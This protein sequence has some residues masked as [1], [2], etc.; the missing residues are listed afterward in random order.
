MCTQSGIHRTGFPG[1]FHATSAA[2][3][4]SDAN[5]TACHRPSAKWL[6]LHSRLHGPLGFFSPPFSLYNKLWCHPSP[7]ATCT[8]LQGR[9]KCRTQDGRHICSKHNRSWGYPLD[10]TPVTGRVSFIAILAIPLANIATV[11]TG[12][13]FA[14]QSHLPSYK[15][16]TAYSRST[17]TSTPTVLSSAM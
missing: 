17:V 6:S 1:F 3:S 15:T 4:C 11:R 5:L 13:S 10:G 14:Y 2:A 8:L 12:H 9:L 16:S 7:F